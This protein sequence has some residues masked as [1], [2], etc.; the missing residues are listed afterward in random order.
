M[1]MV[2][3]ILES[4]KP[5]IENSSHVKT[6]LVKIVELAERLKDYEFPQQDY[7]F[8]PDLD[9]EELCQF[10]FILNSINFQFREFHAPWKKFEVEYQGQVYS[11]FFGLAYSLRKAVEEGIPILD[12]NYLAN[13]SKEQAL[14]FL[15]GRNMIIPMFEERVKILNEIGT[16]LSERYEGKFSNF[17][18]VSNK[19]FDNGKGLVERLAEEFHAFNDVRLYKPTN[20]LVKFYKKAQLLFA[21]LH[22]NPNSGFKLADID[23]LTVFADYKLPQALRDLRILEYS[24]DLAYKIDNRILI[25]EGSDEEIEIRAHTIYASD[26]LCREVNKRRKDKVTPNMIDEYLWLEGKKSKKPR[27]FTRTIY[28]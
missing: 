25:P 23:Q 12:S 14:K 5:V 15:K 13:L 10:A 7:K 11:G 18:R 4:V 21:S 20:T 26:I 17:I 1:R 19:A 22:C 24:R 6:N 28:Y 3:P 9:K 2:H 8:Y 27:H 16:V